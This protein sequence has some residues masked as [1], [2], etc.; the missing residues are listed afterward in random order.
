MMK[1]RKHKQLIQKLKSQN[2]PYCSTT[3]HQEHMRRDILSEPIISHHQQSSLTPKLMEGHKLMIEASKSSRAVKCCHQNHP[4]SNQMLMVIIQPAELGSPQNFLVVGRT[5]VKNH[6]IF[7]SWPDPGKLRFVIFF[8]Q[9][10]TIFGDKQ[11]TKML[12]Y[13]LDPSKKNHKKFSSWP[14][15]G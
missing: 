6:K 5:P 1:T 9:F 12:S 14:G 2:K 15:P 7:S 11:V 3:R 4:P 13:W 8:W 10:W